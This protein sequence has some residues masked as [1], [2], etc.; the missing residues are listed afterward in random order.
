MIKLL[1]FSE[2]EQLKWEELLSASPAATFF[3]TVECAQLWERSYAFFKSF[4]LVDVAEDG[5]YLA[6]LPFVRA[7]KGLDNYYSMPMGGT[8]GVVSMQSG[9][10]GG[11]YAEWLKQAKRPRTER[12][13]VFTERE[14]PTLI[15]LG[16]S[17]K[18]FSTHVL[19]FTPDYASR[20]SRSA[21]KD[22]EYAR[23]AGFSLDRLES[24]EMLAEFFAFSGRRAKKGFYTRRFFENLLVFLVPSHR[25]VWFCARKN[26]KL[27][28]YQICFLFK[29]K[30]IFWDTG[31]DSRFA[32]DRPGYFLKDRILTWAWENGFKEADFGQTPEGGK[33]AVEFKE[34]MGGEARTV[35][36]YTYASGLKKK[37]RSA[38]EKMWSRV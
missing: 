8:G 15:E 7:R 29:D 35:F 23:Q 25:A 3:H 2:L 16:F 28:A 6:G 13:M 38:F 31:F 5:R 32:K 18:T 1:S 22:I 14:E 27:A 4:F 37:L 11:L 12:M 20:L 36:E 9:L 10:E 19:T 21:R 30:I 34:R 24:K 33:G 17:K 26:G